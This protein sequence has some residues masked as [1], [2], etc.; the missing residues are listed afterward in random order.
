MSEAEIIDRLRVWAMALP[1]VTEKRHGR[2]DVP[3]WQVHGRTFLGVGRDGSTAVFCITE[4]SAEAAADADPE[5]VTAVRR[6][7]ARRS[8][9]GVEVRLAG[10][11]AA[12]IESL[13]HEAWR[14]RA[15]KTLVR[16]RAADG[17]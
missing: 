11:P 9:L 1:E 2:F 17:R 3:V 5:H 12:R 4:E 7:D 8:H 6:Q 13:V 14:S 10:V 16:L 15:P